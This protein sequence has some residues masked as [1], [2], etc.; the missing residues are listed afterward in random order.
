MAGEQERVRWQGVTRHIAVY[1]PMTAA[2]ESPLL[3][4]LGNPG[5]SARYALE[6]WREVADREGFVV[7]AVSSAK[8]HMWQSVH[9]GPGL[10]R[11]VVESAKRRRAIDPRRIYLFGAGAGGG[12]VLSVAREQPRYFAAVACFGGEPRPLA[13]RGDPLDRALPV[14]IFYSKRTPQFDVD[15]LQAAAAAL[16][17]SG[18]EVEVKRLD[19]GTDFERR[20]DKVAG[21][22]WA[23][24]SGYALSEP[25]RF[26]STR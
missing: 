10:L 7:A 1:A 23:A 9:D 25:P 18:A 3:V 14:R 20:G 2:D 19:M 26:R 8:P 6:S 22:I 5:R 21:R 15:T 17:E 24:L 16:R 11:V 12:F 13:L 4:A